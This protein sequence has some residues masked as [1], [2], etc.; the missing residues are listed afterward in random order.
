[1]IIRL[2]RLLDQGRPIPKHRFAFLE[3]IVAVL[4]VHE[5]RDDVLD[6]YVPVARVYD[7]TTGAPLDVP[8][9]LN[10]HLDL[11]TSEQIRLS[12]IERIENPTAQDVGQ[13]WLCWLDAPDSWKAEH[14][15]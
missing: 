15:R 14:E 6:Q 9:L 7:P 3:P 8:P 13:T 11:L 4:R 1:M 10:A 2:H 5:S 12:G